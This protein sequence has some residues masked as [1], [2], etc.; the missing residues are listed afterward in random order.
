MS[1]VRVIYMIAELSWRIGDR[2]EAIRNFSR[3]IEAQNSTTDQKV[4]DF[5]KERW[6][7]IREEK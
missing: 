6:Q 5:A 1:E 4:V 7:A 3:V 2:E